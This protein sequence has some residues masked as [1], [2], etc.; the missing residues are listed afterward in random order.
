MDLSED[1]IRSIVAHIAH[2]RAE[3][4]EVLED[5]DLVE[6]TGEFFPDDFTM[7]PEGVGALL[8][9]V[10]SY[11]PLSEGL[12]VELGFFEPEEGGGGGGCGTG[13]CS[14]GETKQVARGSAL[15]TPDGYAAIVAV[16]DV[17]EPALLTASLSRSVGR[18][19]LFEADEDVDPRDEGALSELTAAACGLG[20]LLMNGAS[21]YK[22]GC[23]GMRQH[24]GTFLSVTEL[25]LATAIFVRLHD[26]KP[27]SVRKHLAPTQSEAFDAA[28]SW[29]DGQPKLMQAL[30][31]APETLEDGVFELGAPQG[32]LAR[33][34][35]KKDADR[36]PLDV[37]GTVRRPTPR[38]D[39]EEARLAEA[40]RLVEDALG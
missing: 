15:E 7:D 3:Y 1:A 9:R 4:G 24:Q 2:L 31:E 26:K 36:D 14:P 6:P 32:V 23:G 34:L 39:A 13:A 22:K 25:A 38:S 10:M 29:V 8:E 37:A 11:A 20:L 19:V 30:R 27:R 28:L 33:L 35:A 12:P 21:V 17:G 40:R 16:A 5:P 18:M